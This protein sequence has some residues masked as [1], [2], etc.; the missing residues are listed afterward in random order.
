M[1]QAGGLEQALQLVGDVESCLPLPLLLR[2]HG[3]DPLPAEE[4]KTRS[5]EYGGSQTEVEDRGIPRP[6]DRERV[7]DRGD[8]LGRGEGRDRDLSERAPPVLPAPS[9]SADA[10][11]DGE[12]LSGPSGGWA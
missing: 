11:P 10:C 9:I 1:P 5:R 8:H 6:Y 7:C 2:L 3:E 12:D 4:V